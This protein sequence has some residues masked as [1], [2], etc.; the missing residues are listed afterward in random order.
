MSVKNQSNTN[1]LY[2]FILAGNAIKTTLI[3]EIVISFAKKDILERKIGVK[4]QK[5]LIITEP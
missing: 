1:C 2:S 3:A 5:Q 4:R